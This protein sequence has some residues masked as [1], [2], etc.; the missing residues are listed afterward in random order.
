MRYIF[1]V[2]GHNKWRE[3][4]SRWRRERLSQDSQYTTVSSMQDGVARC[5]TRCFDDYRVCGVNDFGVCGCRRRSRGVF[6]FVVWG[7]EGGGL[8]TQ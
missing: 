1:V 3:F 5:G 8:A 2:K 6:G 7:I 4:H